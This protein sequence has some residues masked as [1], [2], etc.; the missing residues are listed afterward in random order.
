M[1]GKTSSFP[2][3]YEIADAMFILTSTA[4]LALLSALSGIFWTKDG[5]N[6]EI[7]D[8]HFFLA[9]NSPVIY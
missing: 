6:V 1:F 4:L 3:P 9:P 8:F 2:E 7:G 5:F